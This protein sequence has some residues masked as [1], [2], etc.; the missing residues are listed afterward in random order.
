MSDTKSMQVLAAADGAPNELVVQETALPGP[1]AGQVQVA[2]RAAGLN[3]ADLN[4]IEQ[5]R[6]RSTPQP[7]GFECSGVVQEVGAGASTAG[8][9]L[10]VGDEVIVYLMVGAFA[11]VVNVPAD[12]VFP[13]PTT[14]D[15]PAAANLFLVGLTAAEMLHVTGVTRGDTIL[16]HGASGATGVSAVQQARLLGVRVLGTAS[17]KNFAL[18]QGY[19]AEPIAYGP[20]LEDR[21]RQLAVDGVDAA[22]DCVGTDEALLTSVA[23]VPD[24]SRIVSIANPGRSAELGVRYIVGSNPESYQYRNSQRER[25]LELAARGELEVPVAR[26]FPLS[27]ATEAFDLL[28]TKHPGGKLAL[29]P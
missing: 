9:Q 17:E 16:V 19:G 28:R 4:M 21:V 5:T 10:R 24:R 20:G 2:V 27:S 22:L 12:D 1:G 18:L 7:L 13:K 15:F 6:P 11:S 8:R 3:P 14:L 26:T 23:L 25:V 29:V